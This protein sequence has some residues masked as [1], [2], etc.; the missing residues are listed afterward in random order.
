MPHAAAIL[1]P[2]FIAAFNAALGAA[3]AEAL[4]YLRALVTSAPPTD[5]PSQRERRLAAGAVLRQ[6]FIGVPTRGGDAPPLTLGE[7][8]KRD[9]PRRSKMGVDVARKE[10]LSST[11]SI[12]RARSD[13]P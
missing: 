7:V 11:S 8:E 13:C 4:A 12:A 1:D 6:P 3:K 5:I 9:P 10:P 2:S